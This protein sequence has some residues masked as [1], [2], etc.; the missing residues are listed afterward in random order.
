M[1][2]NEKIITYR[3]GL[4]Y[5]PIY[6]V[7]KPHRSPAMPT[8]LPDSAFQSSIKKSLCHKIDT[9]FFIHCLY[10]LFFFNFIF[11]ERTAKQ[12][13]RCVCPCYPLMA[14]TSK[15]PF[16]F[17]IYS[18]KAQLCQPHQPTTTIRSIL[19]GRNDYFIE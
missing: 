6:F 14:G 18:V 2:S 7:K 5:F 16:P 8:F 1:L 12:L 17:T 13:R 4:R 9:L 15:K 3:F 19:D 10:N 11:L